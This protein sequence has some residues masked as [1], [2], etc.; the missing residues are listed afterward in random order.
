MLGSYEILCYRVMYRRD[1]FDTWKSYDYSTEGEA[2]IWFKQYL[3]QGHQVKL[4][5]IQY[6]ASLD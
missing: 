1:D 5:Y 4:L 2:I 6:L 3:N